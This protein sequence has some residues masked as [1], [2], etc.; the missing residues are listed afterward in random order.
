MHKFG[1]INQKS[2]LNAG[3]ER[4]L[5][6]KLTIKLLWVMTAMLAMAAGAGAQTFT[7]LKTFNPNINTTGFHSV[8]TLV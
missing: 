2:T 7:V 6:M 8:G 1:L 4:N 5:F 3:R